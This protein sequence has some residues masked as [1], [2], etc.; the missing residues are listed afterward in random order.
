MISDL[1]KAD[2]RV[3]ARTPEEIEAYEAELL[4]LP[5]VEVPLT[6]RF[7]PGVYMREVCMPAGSLI[8]GHEHRTEHL[9]IIFTGRATV[10]M[11][12]E[13]QEIV[14]PCTLTSAPGVRKVLYIHEEMRWATIH[15]TEETDLNKLEELLIVKSASYTQHHA[16]MKRLQSLI[17][18]EIPGGAP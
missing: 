16:D 8:I 9:N 14:G 2:G 5:Q 10:M 7:A 15:P 11:D 3:Q 4:K 1:A 12:G 6:H 17:H 18:L 13:V